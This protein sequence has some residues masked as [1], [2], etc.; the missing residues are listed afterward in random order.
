M[1]GQGG[2]QFAII[3]FAFYAVLWSDSAQINF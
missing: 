1:K 2:D 3:A